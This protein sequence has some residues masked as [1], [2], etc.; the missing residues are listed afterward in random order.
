MVALKDI[1]KKCTPINKSTIHSY[2]LEKIINYIPESDFK[3]KDLLILIFTC[4]KN[5]Q[6]INRLCDI[7]YFKMIHEESVN[8]LIVT[9]TKDD[10]M[11]EEYKLNKNLLIVNVDDTRSDFSKKII[12][13]FELIERLYDYNYVIKSDDDCILNINKIKNNLDYIKKHD[14]IGFLQSNTKSSYMDGSAGY[15]LSRKAIKTIINYINYN[16]TNKLLLND[17]YEDKL[18]GNIL[19]LN[20]YEIKIH[21]IWQINYR[22]SFRI[23]NCKML[24]D[25]YNDIICHSNIMLEEET[26]MKTNINYIKSIKKRYLIIQPIHGLGNKLRTISSAYSICKI[27][28]FHLIV[29]WIEDIHCNCKFN[30][31][32]NNTEFTFIYEKLSIHNLTNMNINFYDYMSISGGTPGQYINFSDKNRNYFIKSDNILNC[33][34]RDHTDYN[35]NV[36]D[37]FQKLNYVDDIKKSLSDTSNYIGLHIRMV[38]DSLPCEKYYGNWTGMENNIVNKNRKLSNINVFID[39]INY[40]LKEKP[41]TIFYISSS[42]IS[43]YTQLTDIFGKERIKYYHRDN[44]DRS[45]EQ[46][47]IA[48]TD[49]LNL[50]QCKLFISSFY[51]SFSEIVLKFNPKIKHIYSKD[52]FKLDNNHLLSLL[53]IK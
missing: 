8:F 52:F 25:N 37:F 27:N 49:I 3:N 4:H 48:L 16:E 13:T 45:K 44:T 50:A 14:Y 12:K 53:S 15:V 40:I 43:N 29:N 19:R 51:S 22:Y 41:D 5:I 31:L 30:E 18:I 46:V 26:K 1:L 42:I 35:K 10:N 39:I 28:N 9:G 47:K 23:D 33:Q 32:F 21:Q 7:G 20:D 34:E 24:I 17:F 2:S 6:R 36:N 38:D 11:K